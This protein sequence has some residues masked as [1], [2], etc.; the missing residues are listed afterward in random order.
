MFKFTQTCSNLLSFPADDWNH[1]DQ[2]SLKKKEVHLKAI[3]VLKSG[4]N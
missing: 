3:G 2:I 1:S 4:N